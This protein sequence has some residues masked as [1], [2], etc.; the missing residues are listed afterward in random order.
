MPAQVF[1]QPIR[2][3][4]RQPLRTVGRAVPGAV[5]TATGGAPDL[6]PRTA[7]LELVLQE[8]RLLQSICN[9]CGHRY[10]ASTHQCATHNDRST[11]AFPPRESF[12]GRY[13]T[14]S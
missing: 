11:S 7:Q 14:K 5:E 6:V 12:V 8:S 4:C 10:V 9:E 3:R 1:R 2:T 13:A